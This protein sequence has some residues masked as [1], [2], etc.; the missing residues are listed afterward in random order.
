VSYSGEVYGKTD[1]VLCGLTNLWKSS[2]EELNKLCTLD[3]NKACPI[4]DADRGLLVERI[5]CDRCKEFTKIDEEYFE[6]SIKQVKGEEKKPLV[7]DTI[8]LCLL[9]ALASTAFMKGL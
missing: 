5:Q 7:K 3:V 1:K 9:C 4:V 6:I 2:V 8:D